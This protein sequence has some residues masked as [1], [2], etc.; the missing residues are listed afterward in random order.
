[1]PQT[2]EQLWNEIASEREEPVTAVSDPEPQVAVAAT[3]VEPV[4]EAKPVEVDPLAELPEALREKITGYDKLA[5][6][7]RNIEGHIGGLTSSQKQMREA[8]IAAQD[9]ATKAT[10]APSQAQINQAVAN[11]EKWEKLKGDFPEWG[12]ATEAFVSAQLNSVLDRTKGLDQD[13]VK[14]LIDQH[15]GKAR[16]ELGMEILDSVFEDWRGTV[17]SDKFKSWMQSQPEDT[18]QLFYS[19]HARDAIRMLRLYEKAADPAKGIAE[20]R[21]QRLQAAVGTPKG[22]K[23]PT[24]KSVEDMNPQELWNYEAGQREKRRAAA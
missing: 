7:L 22:D 1:M 18:Q 16:T 10:D 13:T 17:N 6:R 23:A 2:P 14:S 21:Q 20:E 3:E 9:A 4:A 12:E 8:M 15:V 5:D 11:P 24:I 19:D